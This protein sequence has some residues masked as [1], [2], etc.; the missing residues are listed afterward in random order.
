M[1]KFPRSMSDFKPGEQ[2]GVHKVL[3]NF[4]CNGEAIRCPELTA[5]PASTG[6][7]MYRKEKRGTL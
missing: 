6:F 5:T 4:M 2:L 7:I 1:G 3:A